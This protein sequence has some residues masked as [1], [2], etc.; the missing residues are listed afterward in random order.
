[1]Q[2]AEE[3]GKYLLEKV[4]EDKRGCFWRAEDGRIPLGYAHGQCGVSLF[5]L[6]LYLAG[7]KER[8]LDVGIKALDFEMNHAKP[9]MK[10]E[11]ISWMKFADEGHNIVYPY[12]KVGSAGVGTAMLR[13][14]R[15]LGEQK[16]R[17][18]LEKIY[19]DTTRKYT[20]FPGMFSGLS[21]LGE[22]L[23]D[24]HR[25]TNEKHH[26]D[27]AYR[28]ATGIS[29]FKIEKKHGLAFPGDLLRRISCD[30]GTGSAGVGHFLYRLTHREEE[31]AFNL[32]RLFAHKE[33]PA[34]A[35]AAVGA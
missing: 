23:L 18:M 31:G 28:V 5:L 15:L 19:I 11:S 4:E 33:T 21:G 10:G 1:L 26:F 30:Y 24:L 35:L 8:F 34:C 2:K 3:A 25:V 13:Y 32:D 22:F 16:Y 7:G 14:Y 29:L 6:Y 9:S 27:G 20:L 17:D 12:L